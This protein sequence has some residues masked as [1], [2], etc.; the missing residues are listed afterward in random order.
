MIKTLVRFFITKKKAKKITIKIWSYLRDHPEIRRKVELPK[1]LYALMEYHLSECALCT[2]FRGRSNNSCQGCPLG[3]CELTSDYWKWVRSS[4]R[5]FD[6]SQ[7]AASI[8]KKVEE[9]KI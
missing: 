2:V 6:R 7:A 4:S 5:S 8:V 3:S 9:W 1:K